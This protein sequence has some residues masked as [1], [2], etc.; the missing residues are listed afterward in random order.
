MK[1]PAGRGRF[2]GDPGRNTPRP[3]SEIRA[4]LPG[5]LGSIVQR[6]I[7]KGAEDRFASARE[8]GE[9]LRRVTREAATRETATTDSR[10]LD[11][12]TTV[13]LALE[14][15]APRAEDG[16]WVA[17]LPFKYSGANAEVT[18]LADGLTEDIVTGLSR[19][20]YLKV[21]ARSSTALLAKGAAD[22]RSAGRELGARYVM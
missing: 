14:A 6:C 18:A 17:V 11:Q 1:W 2:R 12:Q 19:F 10:T 4:E 5:A 13:T 21:I 22:I 3:L 15:G 7:E 8:V 9:A 20:S 16:F